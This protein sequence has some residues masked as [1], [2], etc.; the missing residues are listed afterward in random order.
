MC[1]SVRDEQEGEEKASSKEGKTVSW[2]S[3]IPRHHSCEDHE[4]L[5]T[6]VVNKIGTEGKE[7]FKNFSRDEAP[8][9]TE[10]D[11]SPE[12]EA[13]PADEAPASDSGKGC[14]SKADSNTAD[15]AE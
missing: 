2:A 9:S 14:D 4:P 6:T 8:A 3:W 13:Q 11:S 5:D 1:S 12:D 15:A 7:N 10:K